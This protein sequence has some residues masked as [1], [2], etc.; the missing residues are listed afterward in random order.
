MKRKRLALGLGVAIAAVAAGVSWLVLEHP[1]KDHAAGGPP[2]EAKKVRVDVVRPQRGGAERTLTRPASVNAFDYA[3]LFAQVSGYLKAQNVD[4]RS[5][6]QK[7]E[8]LAVIDAPEIVARVKQAATRRAKTSSLPT[9]FAQNLRRERNLNP[10]DAV[11][12]A[13]KIRA[14]PV[15]M[16]A[17]AALFAL[18][19]MALALERGSEA[20]APL[21][22]AV[23]GG[24]IAGLFATLLVVPAL[25][26]LLVRGR[27]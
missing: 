12:Q 9:D 24:L 4:I 8:L 22:R 7:G 27:R 20:N 26:S 11:R 3:N 23:I 13:A 6:V 25:Y 16:T 5:P 10:T 2:A 14:R 18:V 1:R 19:P 15:L 21:G 17:V